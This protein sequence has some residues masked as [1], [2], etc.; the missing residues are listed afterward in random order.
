M[1]EA[2]D[3]LANPEPESEP[4]TEAAPE[5]VQL[6]AAPDPAPDVPLAPPPGF[7]A[8]DGEWVTEWVDD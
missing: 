5:P 6:T 4:V 8:E 7:S 1:G 3:E 2:E